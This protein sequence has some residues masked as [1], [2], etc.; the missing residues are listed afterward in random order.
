MN[1]SG[2]ISANTSLKCTATIKD[3]EDEYDAFDGVHYSLFMNDLPLK[4]LLNI[5]T[6]KNE[7]QD[8]QEFSFFIPNEGDVTDKTYAITSDFTTTSGVNALWS[9]SGPF[10]QIN[11]T[12]T[13]GS[14]KL[15]FDKST[16]TIKA[17]FNFKGQNRGKTVTVSEGVLELVG[18]TESRRNYAAPTVVCDLSRDIN[19]RYESNEDNLYI[20]S[21]NQIAGWSRAFST[22]PD[23]YDYRI[24]IF[25][26]RDLPTGTYAISEDSKEVSVIFYNMSGSYIYHGEEG[27]LTIRS[28]PNVDSNN[29]ITGTFAGT[30]NFVAGATDPSGGRHFTEARNGVFSIT[31]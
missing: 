30:F 28:L 15:T 20:S 1:T 22:R 25:I 14:L 9:K 31:R 23:V 11:Y 21:N 8:F 7:N 16:K 17:T 29:N 24:A 27:Q 2:K 6:E 18:F 12:A 10:S 26:S 4:W 13:E 5:R 3:E 19:A